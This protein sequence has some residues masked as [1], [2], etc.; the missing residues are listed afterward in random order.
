MYSPTAHNNVDEDG[1]V[2]VSVL[3]CDDERM[4]MKKKEVKWQQLT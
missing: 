3:E 1:G 4:I 2:V